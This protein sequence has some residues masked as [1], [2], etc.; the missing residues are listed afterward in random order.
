LAAFGIL[1][2]TLL[3]GVYL[4]GTGTGPDVG[5]IISPFGAETVAG[6]TI[7]PFVAGSKSKSSEEEAYFGT[8]AA[9]AGTGTGAETEGVGYPLD[10]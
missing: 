2:G 1:A 4:A 3:T 10:F 5:S 8:F 6:S 7:S 9:L